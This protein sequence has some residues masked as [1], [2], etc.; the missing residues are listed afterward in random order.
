MHASS[1]RCLHDF[2]RLRVKGRSRLIEEQDTWIAE[3]RAGDRNTLLLPAAQG[4]APFSYL[5]LHTVG[6]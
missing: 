4:N 5:R 1:E 3:Q 2:F 6:E